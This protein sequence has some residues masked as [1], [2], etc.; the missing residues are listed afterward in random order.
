MIVPSP[1]GESKVVLPPSV[2][3]M[4]RGN[5]EKKKQEQQQLELTGSSPHAGHCPDNLAC[6]NRVSA[7][8]HP[9][10]YLVFPCC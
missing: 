8:S 5:V 1:A 6:L 2:Q 4:L 9:E 3:N 7:L 10:N